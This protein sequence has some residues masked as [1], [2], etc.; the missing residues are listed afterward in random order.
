M[1]GRVDALHPWLYARCREVEKDPDNYLDLWAREHYKSSIITFAGTIQEIIRDP[2]ITIGIFSHTKGVALKFWQQIKQELESN[3]LLV[4]AFPEIFY[5]N[6]TK[7]SPRWSD[8]KGLCVKRKTNP[9]EAT[10]E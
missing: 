4:R 10:I 5:A 8:Q 3:Q 7:D 6:P 2:E 1:L 9:K